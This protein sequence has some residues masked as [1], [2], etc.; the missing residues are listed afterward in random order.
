MAA[1][2]IDIATFNIDGL[3]AARK[4]TELKHICETYNFDILFLQE[5]HNYRRKVFGR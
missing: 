5:T 1:C 2:T 4:Q 3:R